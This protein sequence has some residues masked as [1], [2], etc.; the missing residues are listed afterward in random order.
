MRLALAS[1]ISAT[2]NKKKIQEKYETLSEKG[3]TEVPFIV[4]TKITSLKAKDLISSLKKILGD[5]VFMLSLKN[6][7]IRAGKGKARGR[8]YK[9]NAGLLIVTGNK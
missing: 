1:A 2:A 3:I 8:R 4:E 6:R 5:E 9:S 7:K